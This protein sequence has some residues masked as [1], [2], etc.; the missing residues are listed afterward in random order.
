MLPNNAT[1]DTRLRIIDAAR[2]LMFASSYTEVGVA[3][4]CD[5]AGVRKG[6]FYHFFP[7]KKDLTLAVLEAHFADAKTQLLDQ[8][9]AADIPPLDRLTR[10]AEMAYRFQAQL[11][12]DTGHVLGCPFGNLAT[13]LSTQEETIRAAIVAIMARF[14]AELRDTLAAAQALGQMEGADVGATAKAMLAYFEGVML[15][16]KASNDAEVVRR[17]LPSM[18][19]I[20]VPQVSE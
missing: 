5:Q 11:Q 18:T 15:M 8:A 16:A 1:T 14:E 12:Q 10:L 7:S 13:E 2:T 20:R 9:F 3:A 17:L 19:A 6:S 4:I